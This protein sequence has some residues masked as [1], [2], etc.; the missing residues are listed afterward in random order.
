[1]YLWAEKLDRKWRTS[2][3]KAY[4]L[5]ALGRIYSIEDEW[6]LCNNIRFVVHL[7]ESLLY[8]MKDIFANIIIFF[9][10]GRKA[11]IEYEGCLSPKSYFLCASGRRT[12]IENEGRL[13]LNQTFLCASGH[14]TRWRNFGRSDSPRPSPIPM[15]FKMPNIYIKQTYIYIYIY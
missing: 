10:S 11:S 6:R 15:A 13:S 2:Q 7:R 12:S 14:Q 1:M 4:W 8:D 3:L 9:T 5:C